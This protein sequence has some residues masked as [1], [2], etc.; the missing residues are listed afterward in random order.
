[1]SS[2]N[3]VMCPLEVIWWIRKGGRMLVGDFFCLWSVLW[4]LFS[5]LTPLVRGLERHWHVKKNSCK[6]SQRFC[7]R[8]LAQHELNLEQRPVKENLKVAV[9][10]L[11]RKCLLCQH[12]SYTWCQ[13]WI[14]QN[15]DSMFSVCPSI[16]AWQAEVFFNLIAVDFSR[17]T[18]DDSHECY[19]CVTCKFKMCYV[20]NTHT[21]TPI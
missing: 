13:D 20:S 12:P 15:G 11:K 9:A 16:C 1:M 4:V 19:N 8:N 7:L 5:A 10:S 3:S 6:C 2:V 18:W 14:C 17:C 21:H